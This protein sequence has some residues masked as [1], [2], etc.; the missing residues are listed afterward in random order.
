MSEKIAVITGGQGDLARA[1][2]RELEAS[3]FTVIA[4][5][6]RD[7]DVR[8]ATGVEKFFSCLDCVDLLVNNAGVARDALC[9][10][11]TEADWDTVLD[12]NLN[13]A[14]RC[15][16]AAARSMVGR[17]GG[18]GTSSTSAPSLHLVA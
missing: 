11:M 12:T 6:R 13:G 9:T 3:G 1:V 2:G 7:L 5:G 15:C 10:K 18:T 16:R 14:A 17:R 4:P 8:D